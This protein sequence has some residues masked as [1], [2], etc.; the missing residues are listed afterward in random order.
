VVSLFD[1]HETLGPEPPGIA[2]HRQQVRFHPPLEAVRR[3][4]G[5]ASNSVARTP[6]LFG[7]TLLGADMLKQFFSGTARRFGRVE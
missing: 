1:S 7:V 5:K 3:R 6:V 4:C 2:D